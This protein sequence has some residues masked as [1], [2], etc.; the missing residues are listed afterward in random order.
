MASIRKITENITELSKVLESYNL[1]L[2]SDSS[3]FGLKLTIENIENQINELRQN[4]YHENLKREKEIV[5]LRLK[6]DI[7]QD[8]TFP[9]SRVGGI[10]DS[11]SQ[12]IF[13]TSKYFQ[14]GKKGGKKIETI[15]SQTIDLRL[16]G[17][18]RG[19]TIFY[20][21]AKTSP[22]LFGES[23]IQHSLENT[24]ELL[25]SENPDELID[26]ISDVGPN[27]IKYFS[28]FFEE[29]NN[30]K[31]EIEMS[32]HTPNET[33]NIWQGTREKILSL[34]NTLNSITL[35]QPEEVDFEGEIVTLSL[36]GKFEIY[37]IERQMIHGTFPNSMIEYMKQFHIGQICQGKM[38]KTSIFNQASKKE[39]YEYSLYEIYPQ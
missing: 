33:L 30:D 15:I 39:K 11:F 18:G 13:Q 10:T 2:T 28:N 22:D 27:S 37:T 3:N 35:S 1:L 5:K 12:A 36:K 14:F 32:W 24:F 6:G 17:L 23:V 19:S 25:N 9:L 38:M 16:E 29:L 34:Y 20:L 4:L 21:S 7:A 26:N 31:L 8:G